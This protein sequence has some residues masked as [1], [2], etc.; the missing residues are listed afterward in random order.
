MTRLITCEIL[1]YHKSNP[2]EE[3]EASTEIENADLDGVGDVEA[4][5][6]QVEDPIDVTRG[7]DGDGGDDGPQT[8]RR[9]GN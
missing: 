5:E 2:E 7:A 3:K 9:N 4:N 6:G 8:R 1:E